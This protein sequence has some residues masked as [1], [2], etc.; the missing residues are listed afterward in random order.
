ML[1]AI[2]TSTPLI[3]AACVEAG[4]RV[5]EAVEQ[6]ARRHAELLTPTI[7]RALAAAGVDRRELDAIAVGVG[8][9]PFTG[10]RVGI[11]TA[12]VMGRTLGIP[13]T[14]V[15][16]LDALAWGVHQMLVDNAAQG[17]ESASTPVHTGGLDVATP[18]F[19]VATDARRKEI[20]WA[21]YARADDA[22]VRLEGPAV[23]KAADLR[24]PLRAVP[25]YGHGAELYSADLLGRGG[26]A[27]V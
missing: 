4:E 7:T 27:Y 2:D 17:M 5:S 10:L 15:C 19:L 24:A 1:L 21:R 12:L 11:T 25:A 20:Y 9:G 16:S 8:P 3:G 14:G 13:V 23:H 18:E 22:L 26:Y 6:D